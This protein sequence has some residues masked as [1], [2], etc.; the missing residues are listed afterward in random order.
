MV[1]VRSV[2]RSFGRSVGRYPGV[3]LG[4]GALYTLPVW[5]Y[6]RFDHKL[7]ISDHGTIERTGQNELQ[8]PDPGPDPGSRSKVQNSSKKVLKSS[9]LRF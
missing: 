6:G 8:G 2:G 7:G 5:Q 3:A 4:R 9:I 1:D